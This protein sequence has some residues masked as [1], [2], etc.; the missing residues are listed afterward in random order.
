MYHYAAQTFVPGFGSSPE[1]FQTKQ[2]VED[3]LWKIWGLGNP[4]GMEIV[5]EQGNWHQPKITARCGRSF[6]VY[7]K[8]MNHEPWFEEFTDF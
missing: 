8:T 5:V 4:N 3:W 6:T 1:F 7:Q 2:Q